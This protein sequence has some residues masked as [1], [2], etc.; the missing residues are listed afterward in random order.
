LTQPL[1]VAL[2]T[3]SFH[4][5]NGVA[6]L[7]REFAAFAQREKL[8]FFCVH[9]GTETRAIR[10]ESFTTLELKRGLT[11][12]PLDHDLYCDP[13]LSR[14]K[15]WVTARFRPFGPDLVHI[16]GPG[17]MGILGLWVA[18]SL[19]VPLVAS[20]HTNLHEYA[21]RR[22]DKLLHF[23][24]DTW[25]QRVSNTAEHQSLRACVS[26]YGL[27]RFLLAPNEAMVH[28]LGER[29]RRPAFLMAHGVDAAVYSPGR[30]SRRPSSFCIGYVGRLTPE[31]NV[32]FLVDLEHS[33]LAGGHRN[34]HFLLVGEGSEKE[35]LRKNLQFGEFRGT[36][37]GDALAESFANMDAFVFPSR[38]DTF[39]LV[40]LE[41]M[42]SGV[43]VVVSPE[44]GM[45]V[46]VQDG[47]TG[48]HARDLDSFTQSVLHL[49]K[50]E[51]ACRGMGSA[52][53]E[54]ARSKTWSGVFQQLYRTYDA[55]LEQ[56]S[57]A[58]GGVRRPATQLDAQ[59]DLRA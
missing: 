55:G 19:R 39:G 50:T 9:S 53:R 56:I 5:A 51:A 20:W 57:L 31:K 8:P 22:L 30:R 11:A 27:T 28:L 47:V 7:S 48:F 23:L 21:G 35:W 10:Q 6:T 40:L 13:L 1:R 52:A 42:A 38:T 43:P 44:T 15:S 4:E 33:L 32:R 3:D 41:A 24:P 25:R 37:H 58:A 18:H 14:F 46:G 12:F 26:F 54:F 29:T 17:D 59:G 49:M 36:L 45:R 16:T 34:F 2:F